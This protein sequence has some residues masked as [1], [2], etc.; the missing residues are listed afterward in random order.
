M[1][2]TIILLLCTMLSACGGYIEEPTQ[3]EQSCDAKDPQPG[4]SKIE[5]VPSCYDKTLIQ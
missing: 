2:Q 1:K 5:L 4:R 3:D